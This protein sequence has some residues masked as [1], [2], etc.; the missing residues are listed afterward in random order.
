MRIGVGLVL[1]ALAAGLG[2]AQE[3]YPTTPDWVSADTPV[4]TGA[5]LVDLDRDGWLDLVVANGNDIE[6]QPISVYYNTGTG[7]LPA[8][9]DWTSSDIG[10]HGHLDV[11]DVDGD[12]WIDVAVA[13]LGAFS[14][15]DHA[16]KL[17]R[18][19]AGTLSSLPVWESEPVAHAFGCAF[20]DVD[21]DGRP[22]LAV[23]T[24]WAY[25]NEYRYPTWVFR[26]VDGDLETTPGWA[27]SDDRHLLGVAWV[28]ADADGWLDLVGAA[29]GDESVVWPNTGGT[30]AVQPAWESDD[31]SAQFAIMVATGDVD[32]DGVPDLIVTDNTQ[33]G[34][35]GS[36]RAYD[37]VA[38]G[39]FQTLHGW[40]WYDGYGSAVALADVDAD[41]D[42]DLGTGAWWDRARLFLGGPDGLPTAPD[43]SS[44]GT[45]VVEKIVFG[46]VDRRGVTTRS[47]AAPADG[48]RLLQLPDRTL[49]A[50][51]GVEVDGVVLPPDRYAADLDDGRVTI[52]QAATVGVTVTY[53]R[54]SS[55]DMVVA[56][57]N[58]TVGNQM[59]LNLLEPSLFVDGFESG[60]TMAWS[61][62]VP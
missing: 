6:R 30:L 9:P 34:G 26:N 19:V 1:L 51:I 58:S 16:A 5:A 50:V 39:W 4:S 52:D 48:R 2:D 45:S 25:G 32:G 38:G 54:S 55:L 17:Y 56:N 62:V 12:G 46:D 22:D 37:G 33:L 24:G 31:A 49:Y 35:S 7:A 20:G 14:H 59:Y 11:A 44:A 60:G 10:F 41:G 8:F 21:N 23:A 13:E 3:V 57:W 36:F 15:F 27:S 29:T 18:N 43:W 47:V 28:D 53:Q 40:S 42:L 61:T